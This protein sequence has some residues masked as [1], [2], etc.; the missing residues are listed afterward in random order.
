VAG[1]ERLDAPGDIGAVGDP[2]A[3][4]REEL[5]EPGAPMMT[6]PTSVMDV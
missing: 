4:L 3:S 6:R 1:A 5:R 2:D